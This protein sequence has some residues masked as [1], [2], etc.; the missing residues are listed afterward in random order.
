MKYLILCVLCFVLTARPGWSSE[1]TL[2]HDVVIYGGTS[3]AVIAAVQCHRMGKSVVIVS[4]DK[5][6]GGL[7][8]G[9]L[10][11]TDI[12]NRL[13]VGGLAREFYEKVYQHYENPEAWTRE[14]PDAFHQKNIGWRKMWKGENT[15]WVFEPHVAEA[16]FDQFISENNLPVFRD[17]WLDREHGVAKDAGRIQSITTL[18]GKVF[19]GKV[20]IDA[21][22][23]GDLLAA[24]GVSYHVGREANSVYGEKWNG[25]QQGVFHHQHHF[26]GLNVSPYK[27]KG[28][29]SSGVLA[30]IS[31][32][33]LPPNGTG[34]DKVQAYCFRMCLT[35][36]PGNRITFPKPQNYD[37]E[38]YELLL[39]IF[40]VMDPMYVF[41][42]FDPVPNNKTDTNNHG[43]FSFDNLGM[44]WDYPE[45]S[46]ERRKEIIEEHKTYQLGMLYFISHDPRVP[47]QLQKAMQEWGLP[48][49][50]FVDNG[51]W[52]H[53]LYVREARRMVGQYVITEHDLLGDLK[54]KTEKSIGMGSYGIDSHNIQRFIDSDGYVQNEGD[55]GVH[56]GDYRIPYDVIVPKKEEA[57]NLIVPVAAS[58]SHVAYGSIRMEPIF[59]ILAQSGAAAACIAMDDET[60]VQA[61]DY[62]KL[63]AR[64]QAD[65]QILEK[66]QRLPDPRE[67]P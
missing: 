9:G 8:S 3:A 48:K 11:F 32:E 39:R 20:F 49:D 1:Q 43:P 56:V 53:Q 21:T 4:P 19:R 35:N 41:H 13:T 59:M 63:R 12:G 10:G 57:S 23:E 54:S 5:H 17:E 58:C 36:D 24:A 28:D 18:S 14:T 40:E 65:K 34:D 25:V 15:R 29:P 7:S 45:A 16:I 67:Q 47:K 30:R 2:E 22:Y 60:S 51:N 55:V 46:Y 62:K 42:K 33:A 38:Q 50:E 52:S 27:V 44:N 61:V 26:Q 37:P 6:L 66:S 64:L 31:T